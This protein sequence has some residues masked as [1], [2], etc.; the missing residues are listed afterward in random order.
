MNRF[1]NVSRAS[2]QAHDSETVEN[3]D[4]SDCNGDVTRYS[5]V[6]NE[7]CNALQTRM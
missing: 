3:T 2:P 6:T 7:K 1:V 5:S 4:I